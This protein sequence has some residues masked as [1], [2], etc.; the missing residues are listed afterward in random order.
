[1]EVTELTLWIARLGV[2]VLMYIF[3]LVLI[4]ALLADARAAA[5]PRADR[6]LPREPAPASP[7]AVVAVPILAVIG[8]T[9]PAGGSEYRLLG[10]LEIGRDATCDITI[11]SHFVSKRHVRIS[12]SG[13][14]WMVEDLGST[15]GSSFNDQP[16]TT[17][18]PLNRGDRLTVGDTEFTVR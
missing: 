7:P 10:S 1:M 8:G 12:R 13:E 5:T 6:S 4:L 14:Q 3:V 11:P 18:R 15:N 17:P 16:L 9:P 2:L